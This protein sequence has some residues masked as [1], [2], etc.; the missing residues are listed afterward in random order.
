MSLTAERSTRS[1][2]GTYKKDAGQSTSQQQVCEEFEVPFAARQGAKLANTV[3]IA[4]DE[5]DW[6]QSTKVWLHVFDAQVTSA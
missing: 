6:S 5:T 1:L 2:S 3:V 4:E